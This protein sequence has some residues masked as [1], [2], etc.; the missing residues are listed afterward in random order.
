MERRLA[1]I[2]LTDM[3]GYSRLIGLDEAGTLARQSAHR[4]EIFDPK[5]SAYGGRIVKTTGDGLLV[6]FSS[7]VDAVKCAVEL[8]AELIKRETAPPEDR[9]IQYRIGINLGD[10]VI[11]GDD[12]LGD[13]VN[14]AA[15]LEAL[16]KPGGICISGTVHDHLIGKV[17]AVFEAAGEQTVKNVPRPVRVWHWQTDQTPQ[18]AQ[19]IEKPPA[20]PDKPSI[21]VLP[22]E[23]MSVDPEQEFFADGVAEDV[24]TALSRFRSLFVIAR[25]SSFSYKGT[26]TDVRQVARDLG[27]RYV[28]EGSVRRQANQ[29]RITAQLIDGETGKHLWAERYNRE[30][31]DIFSVQDE[32]TDEIVTAIAPEIDDIER[33]RTLRRH[34]DSLDAWDLY[35]RG[36]SAYY[37]TTRDGL[38]AAVRLFDRVNVLDPS[39]APAFAMG[40][41]TRVRVVFDVYDFVDSELLLK[42]A[43]EKSRLGLAADG[44]D[45]TCLWA[46]AR[47]QS[48]LGQNDIAISRAED[49]VSQNP[50]SAIGHYILGFVLG[51]SGRPE[52][53][54]GHI[55]DAIRLSPRDAFLG[56][57]LAFS[58]KM[59]FDAGRYEEALDR[60]KHAS[61]TP[62]PRWVSFQI[63]V[64]ALIELGRQEEATLALSDLIERA[65]T[66]RLS[67]IDQRLSWGFPTY[68]DANRRIIEALRQVGLPE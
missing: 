55:D 11:D 43:Q 31:K 41:D 9:R 4:E 63:V 25:N 66:S 65:P 19:L 59:L 39:F 27:V 64:A 20:L 7:V 62:N 14:V 46:D 36:L 17:D 53:A 3:V 21:A 26:S 44:R 60:A 35:Q 67:S 30:L 6:E 24:I 12:I 51:R 42:Q 56:G 61:H 37:E 54:L 5:I 22:F 40:A 2:L 15:R 13:G 16:A 48:L 34:P 32:V 38:D 57:F 68:S 58:S 23:N 10:I 45:P 29:I 33:H 8:Q 50:N 47:V 28:L 18:S 49:A 1:A 52:D